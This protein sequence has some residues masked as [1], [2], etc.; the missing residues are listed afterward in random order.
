MP[1]DV[2]RRVVA[3]VGR[4]NV[5][6]SA[7][8]NAIA[9]GRVAI[10]HEQSGVTRDRLAR[11]VE[12]E[13]ERFELIDTGGVG[14]LDGA[15]AAD[16]IET[17]TRRQVDVAIED[18]AVVILVTDITAGIVPLDREVANLLHASGKTVLVAANKAD[19][20]GREAAATEFESL[21]FPVFAVSAMHHRGLAELLGAAL[22]QLPHVE[23]VTRTQPLRVAVVGRPNV[24]KSS[25]I[26]K[27]LGHDRVIVSEVPGTTRDSIEVP[28]AIGTGEQARHYVLI[29][30]AGMRK[31]TKVHASVERFSVFRA[32]QSIGRADLVVL[33]LDAVQ[34]PTVQDKKIA[35]TI[36]ENR[37][38][39]VLLVNKW[40]LAEGVKPKEYEDALRREM[41]FLS[42]API[43]FASAKSGFNVRNSIEAIDHVAAQVNTQLTTGLL[44][45]TLHDAF[46][47]VQPPSIQGRPLKFYYAAQTG[48]RPV[49][50][51]MFVNDPRRATEAYTAYLESS[52]RKTFGLEGAPLSLDFRSSHGERSEKERRPPRTSRHADPRRRAAGDRGG[53]RRTHR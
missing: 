48:V 51:R 16:E 36:L 33:M 5:G 38:G 29:D 24:G 34:G 41:F 26:N 18:A 50:V 37:K 52:L 32:E 21:G 25:Y 42:F 22:P 15:K 4:P 47:R 43:V 53:G 46:T 31:V 45:R 7:L 12:W 27:L 17:G 9:G 6:K 44:N 39:C 1:P 28:F 20:A 10:V 30:T 8:F 14:L 19:H 11:E 2:Q 40:D 35:A 3:I 23:E 49:R 13:G